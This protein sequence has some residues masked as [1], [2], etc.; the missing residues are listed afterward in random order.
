M[1]AAVH[2][3]T[4]GVPLADAPASG[5]RGPE[6]DARRSLAPI[7]GLWAGLGV[8]ALTLVV[9]AP[10]GMAP[11]AW[12]AAGVGLLMACWWMTEALP[13]PATALAPLAL[14]P[15]AGVVDMRAAAAPY[16][17]P[18]IF[19]FL[20]GFLLAKGLEKWNMHTRLAL[21]VIAAVGTEPRRIV[22]GFMLAA[23]LLSMGISNTA[24]AVMM[25]PIALSVVALA[26]R[27][28]VGTEA[29]DR[30]FALVLM[31]G[32]AYACSIGGLGTLIGTPTNAFLAGFVSETYGV[33]VTFAGWMAVGI[34]MVVIGLTVIYF[35]LTRVIF[36]LR[37]PGIP[38]GR[39]F[40]RERQA[41]LGPI[42]TPEVRVGLVF[43]TVAL[44][45]MTRQLWQ[46]LA[47]GATDAGLAM[48]GALALFALPAGD[49]QRGE[50]LLDWETAKTLPWGILLLFGGGLSLASAI[51]E[52]GLA[53]WIGGSLSAF[54]ALPLWALVGI[55]VATIVMLTEL[56]SNTATAAAFL[57]V[58]AALAV[59]VGAAPTV[60]LVPATVAA[61]CAFM[62][63]VAT[64][65][66]A[67][68]YGS[69][70]VSIGEM[71]RAGV[72]LNV[73]FAVLVTLFAVLVL[74]FLT[75]TALPEL[76]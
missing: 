40:I 17:N 15:L 11:E 28:D 1:S 3:S 37:L 25:L 57:P 41:A 13:I 55:V 33:E 10:A 66:N 72:W 20:G 23:G 49:R 58:L 12:R 42:S 8:F 64:P 51:S 14:F 69:G 62:L 2:S 16:A 48:A 30:T 39:Q 29:E 47:P 31:L 38:G 68:A 54:G 52:T 53:A 74:P 75:G 43:G 21:G 56:T 63:P 9:P 7:I 27:D 36:P 59:S 50:Q 46:P 71:A 19:L 45:W 44:L 76:P 73:T 18:I 67:I 4:S 32:V 6:P 34:P 24:T 22:L 70:H 26:K 5:A 60:L 35:M 61:S 65:A